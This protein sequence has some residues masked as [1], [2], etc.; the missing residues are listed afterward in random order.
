MD[1]QINYILYARK[2][3]ESD[4]KQHLSIPSQIEEV[5]QFAVREGYMVVDTLFESKTAKRPGRKVF[6]A[7][8]DQIEAGEGKYGIVSWH[9]DRLVRNS[10][11]A[12]RIVH[13]LDTGKL[14][15]LKFPS[16][17]FE[18]TPQGLFMLNIAFGQSKYFVDSLSE[19]VRRGLRAKVARGEFPSPAPRGYKNNKLTKKVRIDPKTAPL[20]TRL[21]HLYSKGNMTL[22][23]SRMFL[24]ENGL[25]SHNQKPL[26][27]DRVKAMLTNPFYYGYFKLNTMEKSTKAFTKPSSARN[28]LT[29]YK[30]P[31]KSEALKQRTGNTTYPL[32]ALSL[33]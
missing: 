13:L 24:F 19:N 26:H 4:E 33:C 7:L 16:F 15:D 29:R 17:W 6:S 20:I 3:T 31:S 1:K 5:K 11:D 12:G 25:K 8:L 23:A 10:V 21:F 27:K 30:K 22:E 28:F 32:L 9:P 14:L 18:N 2:S